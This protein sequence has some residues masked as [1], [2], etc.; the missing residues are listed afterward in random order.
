MAV[1]VDIEAVKRRLIEEREGILEERR[2]LVEDT[3]RSLEEAVDEDGND[4]HMAD[5]A[6]E[7][8]ERGIEL[9]LEDNADHLLAAVDAALGR[10]DAGTYGACERCAKPIAQERLEALP[11]ATKCIECKRLEERG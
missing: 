6:S 2:R 7:T 8:L 10:I 3:S 9:S 11:W 1:T 5:S 4:S